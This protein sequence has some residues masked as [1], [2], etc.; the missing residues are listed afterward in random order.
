MLALFHLIVLHVELV[1]M[2]DLS[3]Y[4]VPAG[5]HTTLGLS[6]LDLQLRF[7][8]LSLLPVLL[9]LLHF[10]RDLVTVLRRNS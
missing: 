1:N 7:K 6:P 2:D 3:G 8:S 10:L 9:D 4:V 5:F